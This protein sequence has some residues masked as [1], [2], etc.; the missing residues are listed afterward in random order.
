MH[1][2]LLFLADKFVEGAK[3]ASVAKSWAA[4]S[5]TTM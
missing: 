5:S 2:Y 1:K 3:A 4:V